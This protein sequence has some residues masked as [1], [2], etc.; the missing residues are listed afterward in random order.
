[1]HNSPNDRE[2]P[3]NAA[4]DMNSEADRLVSLVEAEDP[5]DMPYSE[6]L[7]RQLQA[8]NERFKDR[9]EK[10]KLLQN[11]AETGGVTE[12]RRMAD[13]V[14]LL[15]AHTAYK[16]YP[17]NWL[18]ERKWDR[19]GRWLDTVSTRRVGPTGDGVGDLDDWLVRLEDQGHFV[20]CSSGTT[21]KCAMMNA[22]QGDLD[23]ASE[24]LVRGTA[25][26]AGLIPSRDRRMISLGQTANTPRN[27]ANRRAMVQAYNL[28]GVEPFA[29]KGP[30]VTIG[31]ITEMV[32]LRKK[33]AEGTAM[34]AEIAH[35]EAQAAAREKA[36]ESAVEQAADALIESRDLKVHISGLFAP[37]YKVCELIRAKGYSGK[38]FSPENTGFIGGGLKRVALPPNYREYIYETLNLAPE[39]LCQGYGMQELNTNAIRCKA[40]RY[41]MAPWVMLLL[42]DESGDNLIEPAPTGEVEGRAAF[43]DISME[44]RWG[45]LISGDKVKVTWEPCACGARSPSVAYEI[46]RYADGPGGDKISCS[47]NIDAYVRGV[48]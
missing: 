32:V 1:M 42:L 46:E 4:V 7:P 33:I 44:G 16:S 24:S 9:I 19:L 12:I 29:P 27:M 6:V 26:G 28:P 39:R 14:P 17:E 18:M 45:G 31:G 35:F 36:M 21:G 30:P 13:I 23:F 5:F 3:M 47:G 11:R 48:I 10:I 8:I 34:P 25:W 40:Q 2:T 15:F 38:D 22:T 43:F 41:H 37:M 20:S